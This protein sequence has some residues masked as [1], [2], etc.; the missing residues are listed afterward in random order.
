[1]GRPGRRRVPPVQHACARAKPYVTRAVSPT[2]ST[3]SGRTKPPPRH[4]KLATRR[5]RCA[6][7]SAN[8]P[9][10]VGPPGPAR[11]VYEAGRT[12]FALYRAARAAGVV[13]EV[14]AP[15]KTAR[16]SGDR[17]KNDRK[18]AE[19]LARLAMAGQLTR[20]AVPSEFVE[21]ARHLSRTREQVRGDLMSARHRVWKLLLAPAASSTRI[22][23]GMTR[24]KAGQSRSGTLRTFRGGP[25]KRSRGRRCLGRAVDGYTAIC[26]ATRPCSNAQGRAPAGGEHSDA[27]G[28]GDQRRGR[29][30]RR[31]GL[32]SRPGQAHLDPTAGGVDPASRD[33]RPAGA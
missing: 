2:H 28:I 19:L 26:R 10:L 11:V 18:D 6:D 13:I 16:P 33:R 31:L 1:M 3:T 21:A 4:P 8:G 23:C 22:G 32:R 14:I 20:P 9:W 30:A 7:L 5:T 29:P 25:R 24:E 17:V 27:G 15:S 12:G